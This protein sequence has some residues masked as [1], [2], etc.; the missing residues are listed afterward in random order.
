MVPIY[1]IFM[2]GVARDEHIFGLTLDKTIK[3]IL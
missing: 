1:L 2:Y 3:I